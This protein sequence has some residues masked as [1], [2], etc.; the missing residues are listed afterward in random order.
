VKRPLVAAA[1]LLL[2]ALAPSAAGQTAIRTWEVFE[3][4]VKAGTVL[5][6]PYVHGLPDGGEPLARVLF[7]G[8]D[9][10]AKG[11]RYL[12]PAFWDGGGSWK[13]RFAPPAPGEWS[14]QTDSADPALGA[15]SGTLRA[16]GWSEAD[17]QTNP[18]R[19]GLV[20]VAESGRYFVYADGTPFLWIGDTWW[21]W[22]KKGIEFSSFQ[23][24]ADDRAAKGFTVGQ[25]F[26]GG[27]GGLLD[28]T[29]SIPDLDQIRKVERFIAYANS[30]GI[31]V[32]IHAWWSRK[33]LNET[34]GPEKM[35][36]WWRYVVHRL[37]AYNVIWVLAGEYNM[38]NYG[39]L[40]LRFW[41]DL[42]AMIRA[43]DPYERIIGT[44]PTP[45]LW[46]GGADAPQWSTGEVLHNEPWLDYNQSQPGHGKARNEMIP[47]I[48][49]ADYA[50][51][52]AK[53]I[54][55]TEPWYEF[56]EGN[57]PAEDVRVG[58]WSAML[59][60]AAGHTY[61]G[62]HVWWAHVP[63]APSRQGPWPLEE[64]FETNTL[65]YPGA[66]GMS[67]LA[68]FLKSIEWWRLEPHPELIHDYPA[69]FCAAVPGEE[70][71]VYVRWSGALRLDL[72]PSSESDEFRFAWFDLT[73]AKERQ[74]GAVQGGAV[75]ELHAPE[76]YPKFPRHKD[77][78]L[79]V[80]RTAQP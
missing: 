41:K 32:W 4:A 8:T 76:A 58:A 69:R 10:E 59:S 13:V 5:A 34:V 42:G 26:F 7:E 14:F 63:E 46:Q 24:L 60:G 52:P 19:R 47:L 36:R 74:T 70:Y 56:V 20:R 11:K 22:A 43:E 31:T 16:S 21:N 53:P 28:N 25:I 23:K 48:V 66:L 45:P 49:A 61:G 73:D 77:W 3:V 39:G 71:V 78:L 65:D 1:A 50:R 2:A 68:R 17:K 75:R 55:V 35:R 38:N 44:H 40:G 37:S 18:T 12:I 29:Y 79:H 67:F 6:N 30:K 9:G 33:G 27:N 57:P 51:V 54:V 62:G 72:R 80:V 64:S 15:L